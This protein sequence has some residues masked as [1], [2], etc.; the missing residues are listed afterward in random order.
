MPCKISLICASRRLRGPRRS[1]SLVV[2][3]APISHGMDRWILFSIIC[4]TSGD[5]ATENLPSDPAQ[6]LPLPVPRL[7]DALLPA[8]SVLGGRPSSY[9][10]PPAPHA[11]GT[12]LP[13]HGSLNVARAP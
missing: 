10:A 13:D 7:H 1:S 8:R 11:T 12:A 5:P 4:M 2:M 3:L 9:D 6:L